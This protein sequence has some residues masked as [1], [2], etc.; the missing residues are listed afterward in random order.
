MLKQLI[1]VVNEYIESCLEA[2]GANFINLNRIKIRKENTK[3]KITF[4]SKILMYQFSMG[5]LINKFAR[6]L[7]VNSKRI[8]VHTLTFVDGNICSPRT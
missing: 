1:N 3:Y 4:L 8:S 7:I 2:E 6:K 5:P